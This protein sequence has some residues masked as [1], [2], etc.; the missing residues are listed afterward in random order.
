MSS[1]EHHLLPIIEG[2]HDSA[3]LLALDWAQLPPLP[4]FILADGSGPAQQQ[5]IV[6]ACAD[7]RA[8]AVHFHCIDDDIWGNFQNRDDPIYDE[9]VVEIFLSPGEQVPT[10]YYEFELAPTGVLF[11][12]KIEN[13]MLG[14]EAIQVGTAWD[15]AGIR[16]QAARY[17]E[18]DYWQAAFYIPWAGMVGVQPPVKKWRG[19]FY[20][21]ER[22]QNAAPEFSSWSPTF[23]DPADFHI[24]SRFGLLHLPE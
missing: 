4:P 19:N 22:P 5:T 7:E 23:T 14:H 15:C 12:A 20:R 8:L 10:T 11:D 17:D 21:I 13:P 24:P 9:E 1:L 18:L 6:R 16:W 3:D 2:C